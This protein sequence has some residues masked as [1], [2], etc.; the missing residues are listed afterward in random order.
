MYEGV[1]ITG[2]RFQSFTRR[3]VLYRV[4][5]APR[6][7]TDLLFKKKMDGQNMLGGGSMLNPLL[8]CKANSLE[9]GGP[10]DVLSLRLNI[11]FCKDRCRQHGHIWPVDVFIG[12][13]WFPWD[14]IIRYYKIIIVIIYYVYRLYKNKNSPIIYP[15]LLAMSYVP[16]SVVRIFIQGLWLHR[17]R[18][19]PIGFLLFIALHGAWDPAWLWRCEKTTSL[20]MTIGINYSAKEHDLPNLKGN[21]T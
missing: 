17:R 6:Q 3:H 5:A 8:D 7:L 11:Q 10:R 12:S 2:W 1:V 4:P 20:E 14:I 18:P 16:S 19:G 21:L 15:Q 13:P 9:L